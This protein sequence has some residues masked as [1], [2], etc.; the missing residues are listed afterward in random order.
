ML[1]AETRVI[2]VYSENDTTLINT[3]WAKCSFL[4]F[5]ACDEVTGDWRKLHNEELALLAKYN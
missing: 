5:I 4:N 1:F 2:R 3:V